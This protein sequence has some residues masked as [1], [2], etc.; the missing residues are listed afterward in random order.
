MAK[1][2]AYQ[3][4]AP[5]K[6][7]TTPALSA[8]AAVAMTGP[9]YKAIVFMVA[10]ALDIV[11]FNGHVETITMPAGAIYPL[12]NYGALTTSG[13]TEGEFVCLYD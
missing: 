5:A 6:L 4:S 10:G 7:H 13:L 2:S 9:L 8:T 3:T 12:Q 1:Y 11:D